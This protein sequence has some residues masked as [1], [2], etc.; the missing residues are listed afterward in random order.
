MDMAARTSY[1]NA[2]VANAMIKAMGMQAENTDR[3]N[4]GLTVA[5]NDETFF[6]LIDEH[7]IGHNNVIQYL[8]D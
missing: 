6:N 1:I 5:Y 7:G 2:M 3:A 4:R 8:R